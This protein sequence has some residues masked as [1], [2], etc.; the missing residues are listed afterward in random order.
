MKSLLFIFLIPII[1]TININAQNNFKAS[2]KDKETD[3]YLIGVNVF[4]ADTQLGAATNDEGFVEIK[5]IPD[6]TF[7]IKFSFIGYK[8][9][10]LQITFP[11]NSTETFEIFM[12]EEAEELEEISVSSTRATRMIDDVPT[13][14]EVI[15]GEEIGEKI[16]MDPS[17]ISMM[18]SESTGIQVQQ[19]SASS[20][21]N[22]F[23]IQGLEGRY[24][25]LLKDGLP[26]YA[27]FSGSLSISQILPLDLKQIEIIK[28][29]SSTLYGGGA[30]AGLINLVSKE[31]SEKRELSFLANATSALGFDLS[32]YFSQKFDYYGIALLASRNSQKIYDNND[33]NFSDLPQI[34]RYTFNPSF[35]FYL[36]GKSTLQIGGTIVNENRLG[37]SVK[38]IEGGSNANNEFTEENQ[39]NRY[40]GKIL[41]NY[42]FDDYRSL[43]I[44]S[45]I[46]Y[47]NRNIELPD[48]KFEGRQFSSFS[49]L[50]YSTKNENTEWIFGINLSTDD[51]KDVNYY[52]E[53]RNYSDLTAGAFVQNIF[54]LNKIIS[55]ESGLRADYNKD[56]GWFYLPRISILVKLNHELTSR[57]GGGLGY[58]IPAIF[59]EEA[60][61]KSFR[62]ILPLNKNLIDSEQSYGLN[63]DMNYKTVLFDEMTFSLNQLF[64]YTRI[65]DPLSLE[66][67]ETLPERYNFISLA[68]YFDTRGAETNLKFTYEEYK[69]FIGYTYTDARLNTKNY[70]KEF[71]LTPKH[72]VGIVLFYEEHENFRIGLEAYYTSPQKL[73]SGT[74]TTGYWINGLMIEK[75]FENISIFLNLENFLDTR[76]SK[77][78]QMYTGTASNPEFVEIY[79]PTD[80]R[81]INAGIKVSL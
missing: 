26:L 29:S 7:I 52:A 43:A 63:F 55:I 35:Y 64:F 12:E 18:L 37:G 49:E 6:G 50:T 65:N 8:E 80:G 25:Q 51:Y 68:G 21:N 2:V 15:A 57:F 16:S 79:A 23:R 14:V 48:Y 9:E 27:G 10:S 53:K 34:E 33:D 67:S 32:G 78:G 75:R 76:Q 58:K 47:F 61:N 5:N 56:Y 77:Y 46:G 36:N 39:S 59:T 69:L 62:N 71:V 22:T 20:V 40:T 19:T 44:K 70:E 38:K 72:K 73:S 17:N 45:S 11:A 74:T 28:G 31:P 1:C 60:E 4:I 66:T 24:T 13:R 30:I 42:E 3:E 81:I 54:E 41:Y